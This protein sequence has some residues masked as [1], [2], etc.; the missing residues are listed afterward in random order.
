MGRHPSKSQPF[1]AD[2]KKM[3][4]ANSA[5]IQRFLHERDLQVEVD[6]KPIEFDIKIASIILLRAAEDNKRPPDKFLYYCLFTCFKIIAARPDPLAGGEGYNVM[7]TGLGGFFSSSTYLSTKDSSTGNSMLQWSEKLRKALVAPT[8]FGWETEF[9]S[10][11][12]GICTSSFRVELLQWADRTA[13]VD[14]GDVGERSFSGIQS[15]FA[16]CLYDLWIAVDA[17]QN[18]SL[19]DH[20]IES[21]QTNL[22]ESIVRINRYGEGSRY[23]STSRY[24][25]GAR[26]EIEGN[27]FSQFIRQESIAVIEKTGDYKEKEAKFVELASK[28]ESRFLSFIGTY[29]I[30]E[31]AKDRHYIIPDLL[32][33]A[34]PFVFHKTLSSPIDDGDKVKFIIG[35]SAAQLVALGIRKIDK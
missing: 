20:S 35:I 9:R 22:N 32:P 33:R 11:W 14:G 2:T 5:K 30:E 18:F 1:Q 24:V 26:C 13:P 23:Y 10:L 17:V 27:P 28:R 15:L 3:V 31:R 12:Q 19:G 25:F 7:N 29:R 6:D 21:A 16:L 8:L 4:K 34:R